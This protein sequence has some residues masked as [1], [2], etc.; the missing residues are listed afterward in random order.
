L[1]GDVPSGFI[2]NASIP[3]PARAAKAIFRIGTNTLMFCALEAGSY[4]A[5]PDWIA[6]NEQLPDFNSVSVK[7]E[8]VQTAV[9]F[10]VIIGV[11]PLVAVATRVY[12]L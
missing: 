11:S 7:P 12:G 5:L 3:M 2:T 4:I 1:T 9:V 6:L 10:E 8:T